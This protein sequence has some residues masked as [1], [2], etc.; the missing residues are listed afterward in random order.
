MGVGFYKGIS[1]SFGTSKHDWKLVLTVIDS[2]IGFEKR[3]MASSVYYFVG[4]RVNASNDW[5]SVMA[6]S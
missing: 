6:D 3:T 4:A 5:Y 2:K 1:S